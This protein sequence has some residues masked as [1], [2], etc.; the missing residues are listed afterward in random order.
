MSVFSMPG[1]SLVDPMGGRVKYRGSPFRWSGEGRVTES[2]SEGYKTMHNHRVLQKQMLFNIFITLYLSLKASNLKSSCVHPYLWG[3]DTK[4][5]KIRKSWDNKW[6][7]KNHTTW[8]K[9]QIA[10]EYHSPG[11]GQTKIFS[12]KWH[13]CFLCCC[14]SCMHMRQLILLLC[15]LYISL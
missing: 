5:L 14:F 12:C 9:A 15:V 8:Y 2:A 10:A 1:T 13:I 3:V 7:R 11:T 6:W 4:L